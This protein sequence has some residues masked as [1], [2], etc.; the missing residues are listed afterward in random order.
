[1]CVCVCVCVCVCM[2]VCVAR[3]NSRTKRQTPQTRINNK[4]VS[5]HFIFH[6]K[7]YSECADN[8]DR[9]EEKIVNT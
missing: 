3:S 5:K 2:C 9:I 8:T 1:M 4:K 6:L 7:V